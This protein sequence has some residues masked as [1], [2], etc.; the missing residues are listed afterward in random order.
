VTSALILLAGGLTLFGTVL[1]ARYLDA[2]AWQR[3]LV[4]YAV[5]LPS[6]L[7]AES[8]ARWLGAVAAATHAPRLALMPHPPLALE[9]EADRRGIRHLL[10]VSEGMRATVLSGLR[11]AL[12][13]VRLDEEP[14]YLKQRASFKAA[15]EAV[16]T[17]RRRPLATDRAEAT[18][19]ALLAALQPLYGQERVVVQ[20]LFLGAGTPAPVPSQPG[21]GRGD[22]SWWLTDELTDGEAIR[23]ARLKQS[24]QLLYASLR[25]G[26][27]APTRARCYAIFG[28]VWG[29]HRGLNN[30][31]VLL[32]R[33][34]WLPA[35]WVARRLRDLRIP[36]T[37]WPLLLGTREAA[38]L[39]PMPIGQVALPGV[40]LGT[41][42]QLPPP[43]GMPRSGVQLAVSNYPGMHRPLRLSD[44]DRLR[45][46]HVVGPT[47]TGKSTLLAN[48]II[49][50]IVA[51]HGVMVID[52]KGDLCT[53]VLARIP[54]SRTDKVRVLNPAV[55][56]R[57]IGFNILAAASDDASR[58]LITD[59]VIHIWHEL[60]REF[61]GPRSEDILRGAILTLINTR[62]ADGSAFTLV[63][64]PELLTDAAF[65]RFVIEQ[66]TVPA[67]VRSF[68]AWYQGLKDTERLRVAGPIL[69]K[70]RTVTLRSP[71]R[72]MLGQSQGIDLPHAIRER[73]VLLVP[74]SKGTLGGETAGLIGTLL[75]ATLWQ[76][77]LGRVAIPQAARKPFFVYID[78]A[79]DVLR[80]PVDIA[81]M[82]AQAR[83]LGVSFTLAHQHLGQLDN[84]Q[85]KSAL[86]G[87]VRTQIVMQCQRS[88]AVELA[89]AYEPRLTAE[90]L[91]NLDAY[92][93]ALRPCVHG[94]TL[95]PVTGR[96]L[97]LAEPVRDATV[98]AQASRT[99]YGTDRASVEAA[100]RARTQPRT[101]QAQ[102]GQP[103]P[104]QPFGRR[105][106]AA[107]E[108]EGGQS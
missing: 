37:G 69:N 33:R 24:D 93:I 40:I 91:Q 56:S 104:P 82:L 53:D 78:E 101:E 15:G 21:T 9:V 77:V 25:V 94:R 59:H 86:L 35:A 71:I 32:V 70:L 46:L 29:Q 28:R 6:D 4:A 8:L 68:W 16:L 66:P 31:G 97:P 65:R 34:W 90:D 102:P 60:Y 36:I 85:V 1:L 42:R 49:Q 45:H 88:D 103:R 100:I 57:P 62:A 51:G 50:D 12:P 43:A 17:S 7:T 55:T 10:L 20:W 39:L 79:Q 19:T 2:A 98:L 3:S 58:E 11:A 107:A 63:D 54:E 52:P 99:L 5:R 18:A 27:S 67:G 64:V 44:T 61:W 96:T 13:G 95:P 72:L 38:G 108:S 30:Q 23:A 81:D 84:R 47:G 73:H 89:K 80:L 87:T 48:L 41:A 26:V 105:R 83:G 22:Q 14:D 75:L 92:E 106:K 74:L 76:A